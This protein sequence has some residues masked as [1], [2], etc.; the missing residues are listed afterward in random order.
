VGWRFHIDKLSS[1]GVKQFYRS[2]IQKVQASDAM[3]AAFTNMAYDFSTSYPYDKTFRVRVQIL[4][5][6]NGS[7]VGSALLEVDWF[8]YYE[9][10]A[11]V[12]HI[13]MRPGC[14]GQLP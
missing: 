7:D 5:Y 14:R 10:V 9:P 3:P 1:N 8:R 13:V 2:P 6:R 4:W 11:N 12:D